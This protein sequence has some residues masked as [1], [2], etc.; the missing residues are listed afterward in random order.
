MPPDCPTCGKNIALVGRVHN[1]MANRTSHMANDMANGNSSS[2]LTKVTPLGQAGSSDTLTGTLSGA[3]P[4]G[5]TRACYRYR[6]P[7][8][9]REYMRGYMRK[10][11]AGAPST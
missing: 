6:D 9:R 4:N 1:C 10:K 2:V 5:I 11:R 3:S 8:K 7:E